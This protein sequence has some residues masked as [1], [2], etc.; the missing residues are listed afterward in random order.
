MLVS[1][2]GV[3]RSQDDPTTEAIAQIDHGSAAAEPDHVRKCR[4]QRQDQD[5]RNMKGFKDFLNI[6]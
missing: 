4:P 6:S 3:I 5:L 1:Y 2:L